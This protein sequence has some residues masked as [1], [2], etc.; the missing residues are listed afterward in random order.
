M[1][2]RPGR[3]DR[4][5]L[6]EVIVRSLRRLIRRARLV[7]AV[8]GIGAAG[9]LALGVLLAIM[10]IDAGLVIFSLRVR[11]ALSL[12]GL[13][14]TAVGAGWLLARPLARSLT[15]DG[16]ARAIESQHPE[17]QERISSAVELL[18]SSDAPESRGSEALIAALVAKA[19][20][21]VRLLRPRREIT[22]RRA[23]PALLTAFGLAAVLSLLLLA[24]PART[25]RLLMRAVGPHLNLAN[26]SGDDLSV[27]P[28][29][30][31]ITE[32]R[33][34]R[35]EVD[36]ASQAVRGAELRMPRG[37]GTEAVEPMARLFDPDSPSRRFALT[38]G[39]NQQGFRYRVHAGD[40]L[41]RY[42]TV[43]VVPFPALTDLALRYDYPDY[44]GLAPRVERPTDGDISAIAGTRVTVRAT[45][46]T[47]V[48]SA[49]LIVNG[50]P[51][52][53]ATSRLEP[54]E[55]GTT[56]F[57]LGLELEP[58][59]AGR[60]RAAF[61]D[62]YGFRNRPEEHAI[63]ALPDLPPTVRIL[64]PQEKRLRLRPDDELPLA[65]AIGDDFGITGAELVLDTD[66][67]K[68]APVPVALPGADGPPG[69]VTTGTTVLDLG[70]VGLRG[71][72]R[73]TL[74]LRATDSLPPSL[75]GPQEGLSEARTI[76]LDRA[77]LSFVDQ[78]LLAWGEQ[79]RASLEGLLAE[80]SAARKDS[81]RAAPGLGR[82]DDIPPGAREALAGMLEHL[83]TAE[84]TARELSQQLAWSVFGPLGPRLEEVA[85]ERIA[86]AANLAGQVGFT[87]RPEQRT[88]LADEADF[89]VQ[90]A[91][92]AVS[93]ML[94]EFGAM[95]RAARRRQELAELARAEAELAAARAAM[96]Q[97][98]Q[99]LLWEELDLTPER[100]AEVQRELARDVRAALDEALL[101]PLSQL[102]A[103][104]LAGEARE[105]KE[106]Q[107]ALT[108][109]TALVQKVQA[110]DEE[111]L[112]LAAQQERLAREA[113][114]DD[115]SS[116]QADQMRDAADD[117]RRQDLDQAVLKQREAGGSLG[118]EQQAVLRQAEA[119]RQDPA[120]P[121]LHDL[122]QKQRM[123][124]RDSAAL[125]QE[126]RQAGWQTN[127]AF[128]RRD[129][130]DRMNHAA[131]A[132]KEARSNPGDESKGTAVEA[133][134]E[135]TELADALAQELRQAVDGYRPVESKQQR[136]E[137]LASLTERQRDL[138]RRTRQAAEQRRRAAADLQEAQFAD[139]RRQQ[140][141]LASDA[142]DLALR[143]DDLAPGTEEPAMEAAREGARAARRLHAA[144]LPAATQHAGQAAAALSALTERLRAEAAAPPSAGE[145]ASRLAGRQERLADQM[146]MFA[147]GRSP[148]HAADRQEGLAER[149]GHLLEDADGVRE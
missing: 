148:Q 62:V 127:N 142:A 49:D 6:P 146:R 18:S 97:A 28:G 55:Y 25:W 26:L 132:A 100:W 3:E 27:T 147:G 36:V 84:G 104:D 124:A 15:L 54:A 9:A 46:N 101:W 41:S 4:A 34:V 136:T 139:L 93:Q 31:L 122:S 115:L 141:D 66:V 44:T 110:L 78:A 80:L 12:S 143:A 51:R 87:E 120:A 103:R 81:A 75:K 53:D 65:F 105:L 107:D 88:E 96:E 50:V 77:A 90:M 74:R 102:N 30:L 39:P 99:D 40:A 42:Y 145:D 69:A 58:G 33:S 137:R 109:D 126:A 138:E 86:P 112:D 119:A 21:D 61:T 134:K 19:S 14:V 29:D 47:R 82:S 144:E 60:W 116:H 5:A 45:T 8:R 113:A 35:I 13:A 32:G 140:D 48:E 7:I 70:A 123:L 57:E 98:P 64:E 91:E 117:I 149:T 108:A 52:P 135:A 118:R 59:L 128:D 56:A 114:E 17:L 73:L 1:R 2:H 94:D 11:Y 111:L 121:Q 131:D 129:P 106:Q 79:I 89:Q 67:G 63:E 76:E 10:A 125:R 83:D 38:V 24:W 22:F 37:D 130:T 68:P 71:A 133:V 95:E 72:R 85:D 43:Q 16:V 20:Q 92:A 23:R